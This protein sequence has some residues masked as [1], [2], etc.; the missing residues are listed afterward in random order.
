MGS[1]Y[2]SGGFNRFVIFRLYFW[3]WPPTT[4]SIEMTWGKSTL[5]LLINSDQKSNFPTHPMMVFRVVQWY[6]WH[7]DTEIWLQ[8]LELHPGSYD[9]RGGNRSKRKIS[10]RL[11]KTPPQQLLIFTGPIWSHKRLMM[12]GGEHS[13]ESCA[14]VHPVTVWSLDQPHLSYLEMGLWFHMQTGMNHQV[15]DFFWSGHGV[16]CVRRILVAAFPS[17]GPHH[18]NHN[19][20]NMWW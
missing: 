2:L 4:Q 12:L 14:I 8:D 20:P 13:L 15:M 10:G 6:G 18:N 19:T 17:W 11:W 1:L 3:W 7:V 16:P 5:G 9:A